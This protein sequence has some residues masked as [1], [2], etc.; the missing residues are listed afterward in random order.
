METPK[1]TAKRTENSSFWE[2]SL[3]EYRDEGGHYSFNI[4]FQC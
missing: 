2:T 1:R 4:T 3:G